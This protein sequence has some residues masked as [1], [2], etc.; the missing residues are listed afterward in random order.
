MYFSGDI[1]ALRNACGIKDPVDLEDRKEMLRFLLRG[2]SANLD[3]ILRA[4]HDHLIRLNRLDE[5]LKRLE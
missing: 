5:A 3:I 4:Q 1:E 2:Y